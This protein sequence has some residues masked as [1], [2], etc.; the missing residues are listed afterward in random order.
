[1]KIVEIIIFGKVFE[2]SLAGN[3]KL[4]PELI[5]LSKEVPINKIY[6][7]RMKKLRLILTALMIASSTYAFSQDAPQGGGGNGSGQYQKKTPEERATYQT[8]RLQKSLLLDKDQYDK[9][10]AVNLDIL[11]QR[12]SQMVKGDRQAN[13]AL[14]QKLE[15]DRQSRIMPILNPAQ[16]EKYKK[17]IEQ[18]KARQ[19][20][21][22]QNGGGAPGGN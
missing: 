7:K 21:H 19:E 15:A 4:N 18:Q 11:K 8:N 10:Y 14:M 12:E 3:F 17:E 6:Y 16:Q 13:T 1:M 9:I 5:N 20:Q 2:Q 22:M